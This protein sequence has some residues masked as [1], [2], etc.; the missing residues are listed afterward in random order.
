[1]ST[2]DKLAKYIDALDHG[3]S[4]TTY[5]GDR[6]AF[7]SHLARSALMF[8][9]IHRKDDTC[10][11]RIVAQERHAYGWSFLS[12]EEGAAVEAAFDAFAS[13]VER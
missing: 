8:L 13:I 2:L 3:A 5:A 10:L 6:P 11:R 1:M 12:G 9:A 4:A 7:E